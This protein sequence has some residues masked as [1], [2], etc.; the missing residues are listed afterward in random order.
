MDSMTGFGPAKIDLD[1]TPQQSENAGSDGGEGGEPAAGR[2]RGRGRGGGRGRSAG[3]TPGRTPKP[4]AKTEKT[5]KGKMTK[6][7][8][9]INDK[10]V[11]EWLKTLAKD[12]NDGII[13]AGKVGSIRGG[14]EFKA[15]L[16]ED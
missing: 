13:M 16:T 1:M 12:K 4:K 8:G 15:F 7:D 6:A 9:C 5:D 2:G 3:Q 11:K 14:G 10:L